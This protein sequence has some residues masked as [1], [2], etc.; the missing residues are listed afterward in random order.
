MSVNIY[1]NFPG[2]TREVVNFYAEVFN[3]PAPK[4]MAFGDM[5]QNPNYPLPEEAKSLVMHTRLEISGSVVMFSDTFPGMPFTAGNNFSMSLV[6][7]DKEELTNAFHKLKEGG[8]VKM[9]LQ[10]TDWS[11]L[12]GQVEDKFGILWQFNLDSGETF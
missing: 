4:I 3:Q 2:N 10:A 11:K 5:P 7:A 9:E 6:S 8:S 1:L 12:Y